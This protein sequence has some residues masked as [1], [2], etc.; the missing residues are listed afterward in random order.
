[1]SV[2]HTKEYGEGYRAFEEGK[3]EAANP[4]WRITSNNR[5]WKK[6]WQDAQDDAEEAKREKIRRAAND[7]ARKT[8]EQANVIKQASLQRRH[9]C[10]DDFAPLPDLDVAD[11]L[12]DVLSISSSPTPSSGPDAYTGYSYSSPS[13]S[14]TSCSRRS[15]DLFSGS[16]SQDYCSGSSSSYDSG[17][18]S[19]SYDS[20]SSSSSDSSW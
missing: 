14:S 12:V 6:G 10:N 9:V 3:T 8:R 20:S 11:S 17:S 4:Y 18:S 19:S 7:A 15:D 5:R 2:E 1:M 13:D 16:S